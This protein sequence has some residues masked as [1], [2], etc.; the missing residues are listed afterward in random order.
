[1]DGLFLR[2]FDGFRGKENIIHIFIKKK[3]GQFT[4]FLMLKV[5]YGH[6]K[7]NTSKNKHNIQ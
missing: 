5:K 2:N 4:L 6:F 1:M 3:S 7:K